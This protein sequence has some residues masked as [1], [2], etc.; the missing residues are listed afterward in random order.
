MHVQ[1]YTLSRYGPRR[2][3][4]PYSRKDEFVLPGAGCIRKLLGDYVVS[5]DIIFTMSMSFLVFDLSFCFFL[6]LGT[7]ILYFKQ[8]Q[9]KRERRE[10]GK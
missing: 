9:C 3:G 4:D 2:Y 1:M 6:A 7:C 8:K 10:R 5:Y